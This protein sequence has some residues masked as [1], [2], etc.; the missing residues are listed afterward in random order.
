ML[1][2]LLEKDNLRFR[3][4]VY[5]TVNTKPY[6]LDTFFFLAVI[7]VRFVKL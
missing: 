6:R 2:N 5:G 1:G 7:M 4:R 3:A